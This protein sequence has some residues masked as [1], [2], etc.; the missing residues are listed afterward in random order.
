MKLVTDVDVSGGGGGACVAVAVG[1][2]LGVEV[3]VF[4]GVGAELELVLGEG[5]LVGNAVGEPVPFVKSR[6]S[7]M[8]TATNSSPPMI[9]RI[10]MRRLDLRS[11][12]TSSDGTAVL[13]VGESPAASNRWVGVSSLIGSS[14]LITLPKSGA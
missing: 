11:S 1:V 9:A 3:A 10:V 6:I 2:G 4:V 13:S 14:W 12:T 8:R 5:L 7:K